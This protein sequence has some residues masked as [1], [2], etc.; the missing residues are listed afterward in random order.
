MTGGV[1][2]PDDGAAAP[3]QS[4]DDVN[5]AAAVPAWLEQLRG[6]LEGDLLEQQAGSQPAAVAQPA[7]DWCLQA[8]MDLIA[9]MSS[10]VDGTE[11][12]DNDDQ[13]Q[14]QRSR[15]RTV[16]STDS[17][18]SSSPPPEPYM[19]QQIASKV[20][21]ELRPNAIRDR[22]GK[23]FYKSKEEAM[24]SEM[25]RYEGRVRSAVV[26]HE[27][28]IIKLHTTRKGIEAS[29]KDDL[30]KWDR[31]AMDS[32]ATLGRTYY[33]TCRLHLDSLIEIEAHTVEWLNKMADAIADYLRCPSDCLPPI[34]QTDSSTD[35]FVPV[36]NL[37]LPESILSLTTACSSLEDVLK[38][39]E[40]QYEDLQKQSS[41]LE[42]LGERQLK[43]N[44]LVKM[45]LEDATTVQVQSRGFYYHRPDRTAQTAFNRLMLDERQRVGQLIKQWM[46]LLR[47]ALKSPNRRVTVEAVDAFVEYLVK[48]LIRSYSITPADQASPALRLYVNRMIFPRIVRTTTR[49][50]TV[51]ELERDQQFRRK[52][53]WMW[54][55]T[56][57]DLGI[58]P[59]FRGPH[60]Y[61][62][63][64]PP[65]GL[66][67]SPLAVSSRVT[68]PRTSNLSSNDDI[69]P[70][71]QTISLPPDFPFVNAIVTLS[72]LDNQCVPTDMLYTLVQT[73]SSIQ[74]ACREYSG[75]PE[76]V[77]DADALFPIVVWAVIH[78]NTTNINCRLGHILRFISDDNQRNFGECGFSL[79]I[80]EASVSYILQLL[81]SKFGL[82]FSVC[83][84]AD[85][86]AASPAGKGM[87]ATG[88]G[89]SALDV[90]ADDEKFGDPSDQDPFSEETP[91]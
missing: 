89:R 84:D 78:A 77:V 75:N 9:N 15:L 14:E 21:D 48:F 58:L 2:A 51:A 24:L 18:T 36:E 90:P 5:V 69:G 16:P 86:I 52:V 30:S 4:P 50:Q 39:L 1:P 59:E 10:A 22:I 34:I 11:A 23:F 66:M 27:K 68:T 32:L 7:Q 45:G 31:W 91:S 25:K 37:Q 87:L 20:L 63:A 38:H 85:V 17:L 57:K 73:V 40:A 67:T 19:V 71:T 42:T 82:P 60:E 3:D 65:P 35:T 72:L 8:Q 74:T 13:Q 80:V 55:L 46:T 44:N 29:M 49:L 70:T 56:Q 28:H 6:A 76:A 54:R 26:Q 53:R 62:L 79:A 83:D 61:D 88:S 81:P 12:K 47:D 64:A 33:E 41:R 43:L